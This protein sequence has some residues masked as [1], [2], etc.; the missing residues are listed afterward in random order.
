MD[1]LTGGS[2]RIACVVPACGDR[3][4]D[5][6]EVEEHAMNAHGM[7]P[8]DVTEAFAEKGARNGGKFWIG[9]SE[10]EDEEEPDYTGF[11]S[12]ANAVEVGGASSKGL[13]LDYGT[14]E[15]RQ[16][17]ADLANMLSSF[18]NDDLEDQ[19]K[20]VMIDPALQRV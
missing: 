15:E 12:N 8:A 3:F 7:T 4:L 18:V 10:D 13:P 19:Q 6:A 16:K 9:G 1:K 2:R 17:E 14:A 20:E 11:G 5:Q